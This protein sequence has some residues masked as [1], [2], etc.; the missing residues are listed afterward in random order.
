MFDNLEDLYTQDWL[1]QARGGFNPSQAEYVQRVREMRTNDAMR[2]R[3]M[4]NDPRAQFMAAMTQ[5]N[6]GVTNPSPA[7]MNQHRLMAGML[8]NSRMGSAMMGGS[9][10]D[11]YQGIHMGLANAGRYALNMNGGASQY[12]HGGGAV[13]S[14][15]AEA[16][17]KSM[18]QRYFTP[19]GG[20]IGHRAHGLNRGDLGGLVSAM[21]RRG[22]FA[23]E[24][25]TGDFQDMGD[26]TF[27]VTMGD[28]A[29]RKFNQL[30]DA[31]AEAV[32]KIKD[33]LGDIGSNKLIQALEGLSG[34]PIVTAQQ[35]EQAS[36]RL[37][38]VKQLAMSGGTSA[39]AVMA[40]HRQASMTLEMQGMGSSGAAAGGWNAVE[41]MMAKRASDR[42]YA[43]ARAAQGVYVRD[44]S[45]QVMQR[46]LD[47]QT[48]L[49]RESPE[50]AAM[51]LDIERSG[52]DPNLRAELVSS[53]GG[54][55]NETE[56]AAAI[57]AMERK[58]LA[59]GGRGVSA[60]MQLSGG[61]P[62]AFLGGESGAAL[63]AAS[64]A[65]ADARL[66]NDQLPGALELALGG[67]M[68][69]E[70]LA[71]G[72]AL[73]QGKSRQS[74]GKMAAGGDRIASA[75]LDVMDLNPDFQTFVSA[76][77]QAELD[78]SRYMQILGESAFG[79]NRE[80]RGFLDGLLGGGSISRAQAFEQMY[81]TDNED[82]LLTEVEGW[83]GMTPEARQA[84]AL[85][86]DR[87]GRVM[88]QTGDGRMFHASKEAVNAATED[89][90]HLR[91]R[92]RYDAF[93]VTVDR[94]GL[95]DDKL[96][97]KLVTGVRTTLS[98]LDVKG[99]DLTD[100]DR[101]INAS[102]GDA[103][104]Q[105]QLRKELETRINTEEG[106]SE[107]RKQELRDRLEKMYDTQSMDLQSI[108]ATIIGLLR[109]LVGKIDR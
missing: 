95:G 74:I 109:T 25:I 103:M 34:A 41:A 77:D 94:E 85:E 98:E 55:R 49:S 89:L 82:G 43:G 30:T 27:G 13:T 20:A 97:D 8:A 92:E 76:E 90:E 16:M 36:R 70:D 91:Q 31:G 99:K 100:L 33:I 86:L 46:H 38:Q 26:G 42:N 63:A 1:G 107:P 51:L 4:M 64:K 22:S 88:S 21:G 18:E 54:A 7:M 71:T 39:E 37:D 58:I 83:A 52:L 61:D 73:L 9:R 28:E 5:S 29:R 47:D 57:S 2:Q 32:G 3:I 19:T 84:E 79:T 80:S 104:I 68:S 50:V 75:L 62:E 65:Q 105:N 93:G 40:I 15:Y 45:A 48:I 35:Y 67:N 106:L 17:L 14:M 59:A 66:I 12:T 6:L 56:R 11:M 60:M 78:H 101:L 24:G 72:R 10:L 96:R 53:I 81:G 102:S 108:G 69:A 87:V 44:M 23:A